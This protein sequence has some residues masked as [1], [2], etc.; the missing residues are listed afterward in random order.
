[1]FVRSAMTQSNTKQGFGI[2]LFLIGCLFFIFGFITWSNSQLIPY[3]KIACELTQSA[4]YLVATAFFAAYFI[5]SLPSSA[6]LERIGYR[7]GMS[8]GLLIMAVGAVMFIPAANA[9]SYP[10]FLTGLFIIGTGLALL[11]TASNPYVAILGPHESGARRLS[12]MGICNK[13]AGIAAVFVLGRITLKNADELI[14]RLKTLTPGAK[15]DELDALAQRVIVP[16]GI[17]AGVLLLLAIA[18]LF[19]PLPEVNPALPEQTGDEPEP[20]IAKPSAEP[21]P[22]PDRGAVWAYPHL[23][24]GALAIFFYVGAEVISYD[25]FAGFGQHLGYSLDTAKNFATYTGYALLGGYIVGIVAIPKYISQQKALVWAT[26]LSIALCLVAMFTTGNT[27]VIAFAGLGFSNSVMWPAIFPLAL[28][29]LGKYTKTGGALLI[30][31]IAG[32]AV[33]PPL[34]GKLGEALGNLQLAYL[35]LIPCYLFILYYALK[36]SRAGVLQ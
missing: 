35:L 10:L 13:V 32:G 16:Y 23:I 2:A 9:R 15:A 21:A 28:R 27:A 36:G 1:M 19:V 11:Q 33:L 4:S 24:L 6:I 18:L 5:M 22:L 25:T 20:V 29:G 26:W 8:L 30:M 31:G 34:Y 7:K 14:A 17:I 12:I 3:L